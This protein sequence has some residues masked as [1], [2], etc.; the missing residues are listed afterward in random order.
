MGFFVVI[1]VFPRAGIDSGRLLK[2]ALAL[3]PRAAVQQRSSLFLMHA[4]I[5]KQKMV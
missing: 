5:V 4:I 2:N 1:A 3:G